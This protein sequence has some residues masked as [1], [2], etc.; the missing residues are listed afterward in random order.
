MAVALG[1]DTGGTYTDAVLVDH[2]NGSVLAAAKALT[3]YRDLSIGIE[4]AMVAVFEGQ[5]ISPADV[6][7]VALSTTLAT[8]AI[9]EGRGAP[10]CLLLI[11]YDPVLI[12][13]YGFEHDLVTR[14]VVYLRG[15]HTGIGDEVEPLDEAAVREAILAYRDHVEAFSLSGYFG[16]RNPEHELRVRALVGELTDLPV[17]CGH[18]LTTRLHA[19]RRATTATLN[20]KLIPLLRELIAT[21]RQT[22]GEQGISAPLMVVRGDGSLVRAGWAMRR[23]IETILSGPAASVVGAWHLASS[24][25]VWVVDIGGTTTDIATL[26]DG[27]PRMNSQ[28]AQVGE[29]RT[30]VEAV[31]VHT[32]GLG[33]DSE[34]RFDRDGQLVIGPRRVV[35]LCLLASEHP[36]IVDELQRQVTRDDRES[37]AGQFVFQQRKA[38]HA[39]SERDQTVLRH[40]ESG[41][42]SLVSLTGKMRYGS[43]VRR[44]V[45]DLEKRRLVMR[46]AF[47][48]TD[49]LHVLGQFERWDVQAA[50]LGA[51]LLAVEA[52]LSPQALCEQVIAG[53]SDR[54]TTELV[55]KVL[56]DEAVLPQWEREPAAMALLVR[57]L[58]NVPDTD[59]KCQLTLRQP[60]VAIGAPV[61][62]YMP[63]VS[64]QLN[65]ELIIPQHADVAN[66]LGA[67]VGGVV[68]QLRALIRPLE[69][70]GIFRLHL[71]DGVQDFSSLEEAVAYA[72]RLM[73]VQLKALAQEAGADQVEVQ[74][75]RVDHEVPVAAEWGQ[76][77]YLDTELTFTAVGRPS[78]AMNT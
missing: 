25:D 35:P 44:Q 39:L 42:Q 34:V 24:R 69:G 68:Q 64:E 78:L 71:Q 18:E 23:P 27:R 76:D 49:A 52:D 62:A 29:W 5:A 74:M 43:L 60:V 31:D 6:N 70:D 56:S 50:Q 2:D 59:L 3:T 7:L 12:E 51:E 40:L 32:V 30:M 58:G 13:Q 10:V 46:S 48:P 75:L 16:V 65:T 67:V 47:T 33:G 4:Q 41:P 8:N 57:G 36:E 22:L 38:T 55:S 45:E 14:N 54:A 72:E 37:L 53:V 26:R 11:G 63:R 1:I 15:G 28:G 21:V 9:V 77:V 17:T 61:E 19:V 66:A 20:A 73:P